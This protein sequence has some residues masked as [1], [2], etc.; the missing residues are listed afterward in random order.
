MEKR[1]LGR[2]G[3][4]SSLAILGGAAFAACSTSE[5]ESAFCGALEMGVNH[6]DIAPR[7]GDAE[8]TV[9]RYIPSVRKNLFVGCK[10]AELTA[11]AVRSDLET[12][13]TRL[14]CDRL[15]LYQAHAVTDLKDLDNRADAL[16]TIIKIRE[17]GITH[18]AGITG[19]NVGAPKAH[20]EA[21]KRYDLDTVMFPIYP[22]LWSDQEY[23]EDAE[24]LLKYCQKNDVGVQI[25]KSVAREP[26]GESIS[27]H[28]C[29]YKPETEESL[30][31]RGVRFALST[32]GVA[33][34][35][36]VG[37]LMLLPAVLKAAQ[38]FSPMTENE[39]S[40]AIEEST[41]NQ[42]IFPISEHFRR[43]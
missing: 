26:W 6:L 27:S 25:I 19:H 7:Y 5:A 33:A 8:E 37:D 31:D 21:L 11:D 40:K 36:S 28:R 1:R 22:R 17:E 13:L 4:E 34:I 41:D 16:E 32:P 23:R 20:L 14:G 12:S 29:W 10:T 42:I 24:N 35:A 39:R 3:H 18:Y 30:I 38:N 2:T 15:D 9:G 43:D